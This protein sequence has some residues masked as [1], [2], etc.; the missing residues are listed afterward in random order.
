MARRF[1]RRTKSQSH[2]LLRIPFRN[3]REVAGTSLSFPAWP[4]AAPR[5][6]DLAVVLHLADASRADAYLSMIERVAVAVDL[7]VVLPPDVQLDASRPA[8]ATI[9]RF[10]VLTAD[11]VAD[12]L[13]QLGS[14][15]NSGRLVGYRT[16]V[17]HVDRAPADVARFGRID[18]ARVDSLVHRLDRAAVHVVDPEPRQPIRSDVTYR[19]SQLFK[20]IN[21]RFREQDLISR[22]VSL[23]TIA[24]RGAV[25]EFLRPLRLDHQDFHTKYPQLIHESQATEYLKPG[26][27]DRFA[28]RAI[29]CTLLA[30]IDLAGLSIDE[31]A[32]A[33]DETDAPVPAGTARAQ[34]WAVYHPQISPSFDG[35]RRVSWLDLGRALPMF[36]GQQLPPQPTTLGHADPLIAADRARQLE[37]ARTVGISAFLVPTAWAGDDF[38]AAQFADSLEPTEDFP[39][40]LIV[41]HPVVNTIN[42]VGTIA[43]ATAWVDP[44]ADSYTKQA[45]ALAELTGRPGY[46]RLEGRPVVV[47]QDLAVARRPAEFIASI[48]AAVGEASGVQPW[49]AIVETSLTTSRPGGPTVPDG[50]DGVI[51]LPPVNVT[52]RQRLRIGGRFAGFTGPVLNLAA[53]ESTTVT[54]EARSN[55]NIIP[56]ALVGFDSTPAIRSQGTVGYNWNIG[57]FRRMLESAVRSVAW[58]DESRRIVVINSWN[59]WA[60]TSQ[61]EPG[62][63]RGEAYLSVVRDTLHL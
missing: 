14:L 36:L 13:F 50:L 46:L 35:G 57:T 37:L 5:V 4:T 60:D 58:R 43:T 29:E 15:I 16:V 2:A 12:R 7:Y 25:L 18:L 10:E 33:T 53:A 40:A 21:S 20:R 54:V 22:D 52:L 48:R 47:V 3:V 51:Q 32:T 28:A 55:E 45:R 34:A 39:W 56:G 27:P 61:L 9:T 11:P 31:L 6:S 41:Q 30:L 49:I 1:R 62:H 24:I 59:G 17:R 23:S 42:P 44:G 19:I 8:S 26:E 63:H 38:D